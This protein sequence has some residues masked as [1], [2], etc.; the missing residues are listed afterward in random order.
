MKY[1]VRVVL[2]RSSCCFYQAKC[3]ALFLPY[4][5]IFIICI[6]VEVL[7]CIFNCVITVHTVI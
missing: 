2:P 5:G 1:L 3:W 6:E 7:I 4:L